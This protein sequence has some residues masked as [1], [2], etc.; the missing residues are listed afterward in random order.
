MRGGHE[1]RKSDGQMAHVLSGSVRG[2]CHERPCWL[3]GRTVRH[4]P[5][6]PDVAVMYCGDAKLILKRAPRTLA[7]PPAEFV[8]EPLEEIRKVL[9]RDEDDLLLKLKILSYRSDEDAEDIWIVWTIWLIC[10]LDAKCGFR[11]KTSP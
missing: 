1:N 6:Q 10:H 5:T 11:A 8:V 9:R 2:G 4:L 3:M 7:G